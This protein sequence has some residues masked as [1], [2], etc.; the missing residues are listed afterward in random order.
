MKTQKDNIQTIQ[1]KKMREQAG[2]NANV[3]GMSRG[4][5]QKMS[6]N[7]VMNNRINQASLSRQSY[8]ES[9]PKKKVKFT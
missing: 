8:E 4:G 3:N 1:K 2:E 9:A 7:A 6:M 5:Q